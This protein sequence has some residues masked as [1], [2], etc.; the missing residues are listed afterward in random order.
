MKNF[1]WLNPN[2]HRFKKKIYYISVT[3][4]CTQ[5]RV[6]I[7]LCRTVTGWFIIG[8]PWEQCEALGTIDTRD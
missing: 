5:E 4:H 1:D 8:N 3:A 6:V 7:I 2:T